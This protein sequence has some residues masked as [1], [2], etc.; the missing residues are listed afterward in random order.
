MRKTVLRF[1]AFVRRL[2]HTKYVEIL[3]NG[4]FSTSDGILK[5]LYFIYKTTPKTHM[6]PLQSFLRFDL[7]DY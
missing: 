4:R 1:N 7:D 5:L 6:H 3:S 2:M